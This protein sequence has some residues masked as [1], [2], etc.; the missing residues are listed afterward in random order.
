MPE[1][2]KAKQAET[3]EGII[4]GVKPCNYGVKLQENNKSPALCASAA[5]DWFSST[6]KLDTVGS[7]WWRLFCKYR[8]RYPLLVQD[9][10]HQGGYVGQQ[11]VGIF[12]GL[13]EKYGY[14]LRGTGSIAQELTSFI[15]LAGAQEFKVTRLDL[16]VDVILNERNEKV[17]SNIYDA[18]KE[19]RRPKFKLFRAP[20]GEGETVYI[21]SAHSDTSGRI[22]DK[23]AERKET[24]GE[25]WRYEV[26][27]RK[28]TAD[29]VFAE[30]RKA[31]T[32]DSVTKQ[33]IDLVGSWLK[34][35]G[36]APKF[37]YDEALVPV[38]VKE[39]T[40]YESKLEWLE[41]SVKKTVCLLAEAGFREEAMIALG[42]EGKGYK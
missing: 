5:I 33:I 35:R 16:R 14:L 3:P 27:Y 15:F 25:K 17:A 11:C 36:V 41:R 38:V 19:S 31:F 34:S 20:D 21:G 7:E 30:L 32:E 1:L 28:P 4:I 26:I 6:T 2:A 37:G 10:R 12:W 29:E 23:G 22:Y 24:S 42:L 18:N 9:W 8:E 39:K 13:S 40:P